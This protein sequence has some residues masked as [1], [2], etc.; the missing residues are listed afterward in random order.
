VAGQQRRDGGQ[1]VLDVAPDER[2]APHAEDVGGRG[3]GVGDPALDVEDDHAVEHLS[4]EG[5]T[6][7]GEDV[8]QPEPEDPP[9]EHERED[10]EEERRGVHAAEPEEVEV[11]GDVADQREQAGDDHDVRLPPV[12]PA[13][14]SD[15]RHERAERDDQEHP[16]V[17]GV[18]PEQ[19]AR[20]R[21]RRVVDLV[22]RQVVM[23]QVAGLRQREQRQDEDGLDAEQG[24]H[25]PRERPADRVLPDERPQRGRHHHD[26]DELQ[27]RPHLRG[28]H[29]VRGELDGV[30]RRPDEDPEQ[31][32]DEARPARGRAAT[33]HVP[34]HAEVRGASHR[35]PQAERELPRHHDSRPPPLCG[36]RSVLT[37]TSRR[38]RENVLR[39]EAGDDRGR[40]DAGLR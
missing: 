19:R 33:P 9:D 35:E 23:D 12:G 8:Q 36:Q 39:R 24:E 34:G 21:D 32:D 2:V 3:V 18:G 14:P 31:G 30:A 7:D 25:P 15:P 16:A 40:R 5:A 6:G 22:G 1:H 29:G 20:V 10:R 37:V 28:G 26:A 4:D 38:P 11:V 17:G 13:D 27:P